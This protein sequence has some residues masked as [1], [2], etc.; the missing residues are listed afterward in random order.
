MIELF[1][2]KHL[3]LSM[4]WVI[5]AFVD[6]P[7]V[8]ADRP[9]VLWITLEDIS[10]NLGCYG[11]SDAVTPNIDRLASEGIR[12]TKASSNAGMCAVA[13]STLITGMY[14]PS[15]G[16]MH[17]R[18]NVTL[19]DHI[20][21]FPEFLRRAGYDCSNHSKTDYNWDAPP[22]TWDRNSPDW[23]DDGWRKRKPGQ[24]FFA[25]INISDTHSSQLY[26]RGEANWK[27]RVSQLPESHRHHP[28]AIDV[29]P[30]YP[31]LPEVRGDLARYH[32]NI[33]YADLL[34]QEILDQLASDGL[35]DDTIVFLFSDHGMGM[36]RAKG[37]CFESSLRV[38]LIIRSPPRWQ[39]LAPS[40]PAS[41]SERMVSFVDFAP[42]ML[43]L[44]GIEQA[45]QFQGHAF[46]GPAISEPRRYQFTYR[47]RMDERY[48]L[49]RGVSNGR[50]KY[51]R[52]YLPH[53]PWFHH[54]TRLYPSRQPAYLVWHAAADAGT[55]KP[56]SAQFMAKRRPREQLFDLEAD[57]DELVNLIDDLRFTSQRNELRAKLDE[58][59]FNHRDRG[60]VPE[61]AWQCR[62]GDASNRACPLSILRDKP[63]AYPLNRIL[64][65]AGLVGR[66]SNVMPMQVQACSDPDAT[67]RYWGAIG[68]VA[69]QHLSRE[70]EAALQ[71]LLNDQTPSCRIAAAEAL[72]QNNRNSSAAATTLVKIA[73]Q[74][75]F[76]AR[77]LAINVLH[78]QHHHVSAADI[79]PLRFLLAEQPADW[80]ERSMQTTIWEL[81]N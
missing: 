17:M 41:T 66:G 53:L 50:F 16:T 20:R 55:L 21:A 19:P 15:I 72:L 47:D 67:V 40:G 73:K 39:S 79:E 34:V 57:P 24:P 6:V 9:N 38:P 60:F 43:S 8:D 11:D 14:P 78:R 51:L 70:A 18:S 74:T 35:A 42:T 52:N 45:S 32:D 44:C 49:I 25:V 3:L 7:R 68:L 4:M 77:L 31:D 23:R 54:Q 28:D 29:P 64:T 81:L 5:V 71:D 12:Y 22:E 63:E 2:P 27:R 65:I 62:F 69:Q 13:R 80:I 46:L 37:W 48:D 56:A 26:Y 61:S 10:P 59:L 36:P 58:W 1:S 33:S 30:Y 75:P 76:Y